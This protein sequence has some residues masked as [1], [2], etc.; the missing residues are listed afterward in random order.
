MP[1]EH[2]TSGQSEHPS[3][4]LA[5]TLQFQQSVLETTNWA[6]T[7]DC[8]LLVS[9]HG[10]L[11]SHAGGTSYVHV[12]LA[13]GYPYQSF[14]RPVVTRLLAASPYASDGRGGDIALGLALSVICRN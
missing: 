8:T 9:L 7:A 12:F 11:R 3:C 10:K 14:T 2:T 5:N 6:C 1:A 13:Q 4:D